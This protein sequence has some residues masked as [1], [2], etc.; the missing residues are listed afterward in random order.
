MENNNNMENNNI[1]E[2]NNNID[3]SEENIENSEQ[4]IIGQGS[5]GCVF[6]PGINCKGK[7]N[8]SEN[9]IS[10]I[11]IDKLTLDNE[12]SISKIIKLIPSYKDYFSPI[13]NY[14]SVNINSIETEEINKCEILSNFNSKSDSDKEIKISKIKYVGEK[15]LGT[16]LLYILKKKPEKFLEIFLET[17]I[18]LLDGLTILNDREIIHNDIKENNIICSDDDG[19][20]III[21]F[22]LSIENEY[23]ILPNKEKKSRLYKYFFKYDTTYEVWCIELIFL[24]YMLDEL[25]KS[26][27]E[28]LISII[29]INDLLNT[30]EFKD[31]EKTKNFFYYFLKKPWNDFLYTLEELGNQKLLEIIFNKYGLLWINKTIKKNEL[32][33]IINK[34]IENLVNIFPQDLTILTNFKNDLLNFFI[35]YENKTWNDLL[36]YLFLYKKTWDNYSLSIMYLKFIYLLEETPETLETPE[37]TEATEAPE[38]PEVPEESETP[39]VPEVPE[40]PETPETPEESEESEENIIELLRDYINI[41]KS[42]IFSKPNERFLPEK[43]KEEIIKIFK[44]I[45]KKKFKKILKKLLLTNLDYNKLQNKMIK[46]QIEESKSEIKMYI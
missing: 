25:N 23:L 9:Y 40:A 39:E 44:A 12:I 10:K 21:D 17:H 43:T 41:L 42:I 15:S 2:N 16:Y 34:Y 36:I 22:G 19:R 38:V 7:T 37:A 1:I 45:P 29:Q 11:Q 14:C 46:S 35:I 20:P 32:Q 3:N 26:W 30:N 28:S 18:I 4:N 13:I 5:Y 6:K 8:N 31:K 27:K 24:N 33:N